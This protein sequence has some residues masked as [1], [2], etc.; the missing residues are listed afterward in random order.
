MDGCSGERY[1]R[2]HLP[3]EYARVL[4][5]TDWKYFV[6]WARVGQVA[7]VNVVYAETADSHE[8]AVV[9]I[10]GD[11][12]IG[13]DAASPKDARFDARICSVGQGSAV[14]GYWYRV[15][16]TG[17][18]KSCPAPRPTLATVRWRVTA[19]AATPLDHIPGH[20]K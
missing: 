16:A 7:V 15:G 9:F 8:R 13:A 4:R 17:A 3:P 11:K 10:R 18:D 19:K 5:K 20:C 6:S 12:I 14:T 2:G 1:T